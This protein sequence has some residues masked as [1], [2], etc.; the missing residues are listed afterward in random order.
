MSVFLNK[1][2][3]PL[4]FKVTRLSSF[5]MVQRL[6]RVNMIKLVTKMMI[7]VG[8]LLPTA[9]FA[10]CSATSCIQTLYLTSCAGGY[11]ANNESA[12]VGGYYQYLNRFYRDPFGTVAYQHYWSKPA[13]QDTFFSSCSSGYDYSCPDNTV[14]V[15][16]HGIMGN[17]YADNGA[18]FP[19]IKTIWVP[20][21]PGRWWGN[22]R[23]DLTLCVRTDTA[24]G[25]YN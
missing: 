1:Q 13:C 10:L 3:N 23:F 12:V 9:A 15:G 18:V 4:E 2:K 6:M 7:L 24:K 16:G 20:W 17:F 14:A 5:C 21:A 22:L 25:M 11:C 8:L 19:A